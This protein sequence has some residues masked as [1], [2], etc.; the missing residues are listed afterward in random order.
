[1]RNES[2][3][4]KIVRREFRRY[5]RI[6]RVENKVYAGTPDTSYVLSPEP[7][8]EWASQRPPHARSGWLELKVIDCWPR[9]PNEIVPVSHFTDQQRL[10]LYKWYMDGGNAFMLL[11]VNVSP[12]EYFLFDGYNA[13]NV[14]VRYRRRDFEERASAVSRGILDVNAFL[15]AL[16]S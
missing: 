1:M 12:V 7:R 3:L 2:A 13:Y 6:V 15:T 10:W 4:W 16:T 8:E 11:R 5:G 14:G 9:T